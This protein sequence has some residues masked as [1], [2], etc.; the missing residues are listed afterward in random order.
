[1]S[2]T[3]SC[4]DDLATLIMMHSLTKTSTNSKI[5]GAQEVPLMCRRKVLENS[6]QFI[7][8]IPQLLL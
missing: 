4:L 1:M 6:I 2:D 3:R 7:N 5:Y 8:A